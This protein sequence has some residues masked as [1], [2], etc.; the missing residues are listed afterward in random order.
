MIKNIIVRKYQIS[1]AT[2]YRYYSEA[3][4]LSS[5]FSQFVNNLEE[6]DFEGYCWKENASPDEVPPDL[7]LLTTPHMKENFQKYGETVGFDL[8]YNII[9]EKPQNGVQ[10]SIGV[11]AGL[12]KYLKITPFGVAIVA[13]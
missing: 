9:R 1:L 3:K 11:F 8:T 13:Y 6:K 7:L 12:D 2:F 5:N 4:E 10:F